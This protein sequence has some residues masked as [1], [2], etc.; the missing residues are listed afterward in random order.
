MR[1]L[2]KYVL[3]I[4]GL[5]AAIAVQGQSVGIN[6]SGAPANAASILDVAATNRGLLTPRMTQV[7][8]DAIAGPAEGLLIYQTDNTPGFRYFDGTEWL[9][10]RGTT[11]V[12]GKVNISSG[13]GV[14]VV[15]PPS[16]PGMA[17]TYNCTTGSGQVTWPAG[18]FSIPPTVNITSSVVPVP[19]PAPDIYC[20]PYFSA[21]C[22]NSSFNSDM[23]TGVQVYKST[24]GP[25][26]PW[27]MILD[28]SIA[29]NPPPALSGCDSPP[30]GNGNY[31]QVPP[32]GLHTATLS[33]DACAASWYYVR[34]RTGVEWPDYI[35]VW[36]DWN[37]DGDFF[38]VGEKI[39]FANAYDPG[40]QWRNSNVFQVPAG[41][42]I[43]NTVMRV[44]SAY[45]NS[46]PSPCITTTFG[47]VED[48]TVTIDCATAGPS[49]EI[50]AVCRVTDVTAT[51]FDY[52][53]SLLSSAPAAPPV[54]HFD[55]VPTE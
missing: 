20:T 16:N 47:E 22:Y 37:T 18:T 43:G 2:T 13:C 30:T 41:T 6:T 7:Q 34:A 51:S 49:P 54:I 14:T 24:V 9:Y 3:F 4:C 48:Y 10:L 33:G 17:G 35:H 55:L 40:G 15:S 44:M 5:A 32:V 36:I 46:N 27:N 50:T 42:L 26:G 21:N 1:T 23:I 39:P 8:R 11:S 38:D 29:G 45:A 52:A 25:G 31:I 28:R 53:C 19:P 12:P